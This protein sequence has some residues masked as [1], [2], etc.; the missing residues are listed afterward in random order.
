MS[1]QKDP[2]G[3]EGLGEGSFCSC[4]FAPLKWWQDGIPGNGSSG[5]KEHFHKPLS[6]SHSQPQQ[7][8]R[9][10]PGF[11]HQLPWDAVQP[12]VFLSI[13]A[14]GSP[15]LGLSPQC[16]PLGVSSDT[17]PAQP[18]AS[19]WDMRNLFPGQVCSGFL[20][21]TMGIR[22]GPHIPGWCRV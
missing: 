16:V 18:K 5:L 20:L 11:I 8:L 10:W 9:K 6:S 3:Q 1:S 7:G 19:A 14:Q 2:K 17:K 15:D 21:H 12:R 4:L 13:P 22:S